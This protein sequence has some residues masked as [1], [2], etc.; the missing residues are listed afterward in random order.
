MNIRSSNHSNNKKKILVKHKQQ[1]GFYP[2]M[3]FEKVWI[4]IFGN[5]NAE[6]GAI[7]ELAQTINAE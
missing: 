4:W 2:R 6:L 1:L 7:M 5:L 3:P